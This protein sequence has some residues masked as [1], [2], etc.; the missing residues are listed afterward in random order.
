[1]AIGVR[2]VAVMMAVAI[3]GCAHPSAP[4]PAPPSTW[5][6]TGMIQ[7]I[8][9]DAHT[10]ERLAGV[11]IGMTRQADPTESI[12]ATAVTEQDGHYE[13]S[14]I[15]PGTYRVTARYRHHEIEAH[16]VSV[17]AGTVTPVFFKIPVKQSRENPWCSDPDATRDGICYL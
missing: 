6:T 11:T 14:N 15:Q 3:G 7:G 12:Y 1:M 13:V 2:A 10:G 5:A 16:R 17:G 9:V 8:V 4:A